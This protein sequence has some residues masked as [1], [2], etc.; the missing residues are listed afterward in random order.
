MSVNNVRVASDANEDAFRRAG[1]GL[2]RRARRQPAQQRDRTD[3]WRPVRHR[4]ADG[5]R[6]D[7]DLDD[8]RRFEDHRP[9]RRG[10]RRPGD[11]RAPLADPHL[12]AGVFACNS[13]VTVEDALVRVYRRRR[14]AAG[15]R[16]QPVRHRPG[17]PHRTSGDSGRDGN[18]GKHQL[19]GE[20]IAS[21]AAQSPSL[22]VSLS[23]VR[24]V[25]F[26]FKA[27]AAPSG[28]SDGP[29]RGLGLRGGAP[30]R[31][32]E[33]RVG[34]LRADPAEPRRRSALRR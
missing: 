20:A 13:Q 12:K 14:R 29:G 28:G 7:D 3:R 9:V 16:L 10:R 31:D 1:R 30:C 21:A 23:I 2:A 22:D 15:R 32:P 5:R 24:G 27:A 34:D 17:G 18:G 6:V 25:Q 19:G 11:R 4:R 33:R 8:R 26:A